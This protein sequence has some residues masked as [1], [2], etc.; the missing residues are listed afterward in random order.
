[1]IEQ[2]TFE[3]FEPNPS[4]IILGKDPSDP[5]RW[6]VRCP[7]C[8]KVRCVVSR[9]RG[10]IALRRNSICKPCADRMAG[11]E[12][13]KPTPSSL[14]CLVLN[15]A[16]KKDRWGAY[17]ALVRCP[18][19]S[20]E[21][22]K[23]RQELLRNKHTICINCIHR[24]DT[25]II[26]STPDL[27]IIK[28]FIDDPAPGRTYFSL[29]KCPKCEKVYERSRCQ[30]TKCQ[31]TFCLS[32]THS[33]ARHHRWKGGK[34]GYYGPHWASISSKIR[35]RDNH[36]CQYPHCIETSHSLQRTIPVHHIVRFYDFSKA[37]D[38]NNEHN[39]VCLCHT[40]HRWADGHPEESTPLLQAIVK[41]RLESRPNR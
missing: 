6:L 27:I 24:R 13:R 28:Q 26:E 19:C 23:K 11:I 14:D 31:H 8:G 30:I 20:K 32:C 9:T 16:Y 25:I 40:H 7:D 29:V 39:L 37:K 1:M 18:D 33:G 21:F 15:P 38:A 12:K 36:Q 5:D 35:Q 41:E 4:L 2:L 17:T 10:A 22:E 34:E 3:F